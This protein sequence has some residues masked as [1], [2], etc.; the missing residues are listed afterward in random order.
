MSPP[1][2]SVVG[3]IALIAIAA[4]SV[5]A[6]RTRAAPTEPSSGGLG[7]V[8]RLLGAQSHRRA[9][10]RERQDLAVL[11]RPLISSGELIY[12]APGRL[13]ERVVTP[14]HETLIAQGDR[15]SVERDG[16]RRVLDLSNAKGLAA[17]IDSMRATL[18]G[19]EAALRR[20]F[21]VDFRGDVARWTLRLT[22]RSAAL[23]RRVASIR[24]DGVDGELRRIE[25][26]AAN[27]DAS[28][29]RLSES[30]R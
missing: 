26:R 29:M 8:M 9:E 6:A 21:R 11:D 15:L 27:G 12:D 4:A 5:G 13:E 10:F 1:R 24:I 3:A 14:H 17:L 18:A 2:P 28:V 16:R 22:P 30:A 7:A 19:D 25:I 23:A 20:D